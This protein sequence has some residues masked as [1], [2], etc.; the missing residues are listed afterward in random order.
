[1]KSEVN[2]VGLYTIVRREVTRFC[3]IWTQTLLPSVVSTILYFIVFG[4]LI[5]TRIGKM[6]DVSYIEYIIP[7]LVMMSIITNSYMNV[8]SSFFISKFQRNIEEMLVSP[9]P[10]VIILWGYVLGGVCRG[11]IVGVLVTMVSLF[12]VR[13]PIGS[14]TIVLLTAILSSLLFSIAGLIN[15]IVSKKFDDIEIIPTF[16]LTPLIYLGGVFYSIQLL[17]KF[18][19]K[20]IYLNPI[21]Y[22]INVFR[23]GLLGRSDVEVSTAMWVII[24]LLIGLYC[25]AFWLLNKGVGIKT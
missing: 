23:F 1:M 8:A 15:G 9:L 3:R 21:F 25:L 19:Q 18:W 12:F 6:N 2:M 14:F 11:I 24:S 16:I 17:P 13:L 7:G 10:N 4:S 22:I 5:G 20:I